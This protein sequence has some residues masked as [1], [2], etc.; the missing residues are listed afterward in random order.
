MTNEDAMD[1]ERYEK[2]LSEIAKITGDYWNK[3]GF[4]TVPINSEDPAVRA[5]I[6][7]TKYHENADFYG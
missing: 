1:L 3:T 2:A 5:L 4:K 7:I 6:W